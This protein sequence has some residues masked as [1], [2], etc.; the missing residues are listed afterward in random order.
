M[1]K[2]MLG[3]VSISSRDLPMITKLTMNMKRQ[4]LFL[5]TCFALT[6]NSFAAAPAPDKLLSADT[7]AVFTIPD[8]TKGKATWSQW[9]GGQL[10]GDVA[11]K[12]FTDK[13][14]GKLKSELL[15]PIERE[16]GLKFSD[17][18]GL[19]QGQVT[20]AITRNNWDGVS[21]E[22]PGFLLVVDT[23]D[24]SEALKTNLTNLKKKWV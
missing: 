17:Y 21:D 10:W 16:F 11:L 7:L 13:F 14:L 19:A 9:P 20:L 2:T 1:V 12:P 15:L 3:N 5:S 18:D 23:R 4:A 6:L 8:Y 22:K 24:K